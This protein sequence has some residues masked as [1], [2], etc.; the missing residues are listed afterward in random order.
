MSHKNEVATV[1]SYLTGN[2]VQ[3]APAPVP[4]VAHAPSAALMAQVGDILL[5]YQPASQPSSSVDTGLT[6]GPGSSM[7]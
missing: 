3:P 1:F 2:P 6:A 5:P 4:V 7:L